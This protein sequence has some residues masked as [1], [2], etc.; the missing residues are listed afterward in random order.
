MDGVLVQSLDEIVTNN[1]DQDQLQ[2]FNRIYYGRTDHGELKLKES[3]PS[4]CKK[5]NIQIAAYSFD[6][7][8][9]VRPPKLIKIGLIQHAIVLPTNKPINEQR[10]AI[11]EKV[12]KIIQIAGSEGVQILCLQETWYMPFFLCTREIKEWEDFAELAHD[13]P[14]FH[15]LSKLA[16]KYNLVIVSPILE[17]DEAGVWWNTAV[18]ID[19]DGKYLGKHR[20]NHLPSVGSFNET[21]YYSP[22]NTGH[23]VFATKFAKIAVNICYGRHHA[24]NWLM[25]AIN[26]AEV[27]FNPAATISKF[28]ESFWG[29]E[30]R[31]AAAANGYFTCSI[32]RVGTEDFITKGDKKTVSRNY[33]GSSYITAPN[34]CRTPG[35]SK[36]LDGLLIAQVDLNLNR[37]VRDKTGY[38]LT[39]RLEMYAKELNDTLSKN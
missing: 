34:G 7:D 32:N 37:Q 5:L 6:A 14:S 30:A 26:G 16:T 36:S 1:L 39:S 2:Q 10:E 24:L 25:F 11:F 9:E 33:Y 28:G 23:P 22:G 13:G 3:T 4:A 29:I 12:E 8:K 15:F 35:L 20:K 18:V 27:V 21:T 17:K 38:N 19:A 31:S